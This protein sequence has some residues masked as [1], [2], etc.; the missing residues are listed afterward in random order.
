MPAEARRPRPAQADAAL[1]VEE[2]TAPAA[3]EALA[4][5]W[6]E[7]FA[8][9]PETGP[10]QSPDWLLAW[11]RAFLAGGGLWTL[12]VRCGTALL[13]VAPFFLHWHPQDGRQL[14]LL[15]NGLADRQDLLVRP[16]AKDAVLQALARRLAERRG[17]WETADFRDLPE[18]SA[19]LD[20]PLPGRTERIEAETPCPVLDLPQAPEAVVAGLPRSRRTDLRRCARRLAEVGALRFAC[21]DAVSRAAHL[22]ALV[23]L[24]GA[25]WR[26]CGE[27]GVLADAAVL[28]FHEEVTAP[29]M[30]RGLLRLEALWLDTRII[31]VHYALRRGTRGYSYLH[32]FDPELAAYGPGWLLMARSLEAAARDGVRRFDFLRGGE[33]YKYAWGAVDQP[34][35]RRRVWL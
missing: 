34:Q 10:F 4:P 21:A 24:H 9:A 5:A 35:W 12:A 3:L 2:I 25:R 32:A 30:A 19:L 22:A 6:A 33:A 8:A 7:L 13:G 16:E 27:P 18:G 26:A 20:L 11:R 23:R 1:Q 14:T 28:G 29:L 17:L 15:G 31:A